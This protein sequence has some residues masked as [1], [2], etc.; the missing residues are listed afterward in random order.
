MITNEELLER[1]PGVR[2][3]DD[4]ADH[5]RGLLEHR[6]LINRCA[7]C[8]A[9]HHPPRSVCPRCWSR[10]VQ[11]EEVSG[12]GVVALLTFIHQGSARAGVD[13]SR[14]HPAAAIELVE[15]LGLRVTGTLVDMPRERMQI[16]LEVELTWRDLGG[17]P[18]VAFRP[19]SPETDS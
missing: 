2:V 7:D 15:Q 10:R 19:L 6:L 14:G 18:V 1:W 13:Y 8:G 17:Q 16:G 3:D 11:P 4:N 12:R 5:Y 9:W